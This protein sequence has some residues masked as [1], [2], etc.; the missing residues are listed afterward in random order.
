[1]HE[2][3]R[4]TRVPAL[5]ALGL[6]ALMQLSVFQPDERVEEN[7]IELV[8]DLDVIAAEPLRLVAMKRSE[9]RCDDVVVTPPPLVH[10]E[11]E[12]RPPSLS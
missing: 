9:P 7:D 5:C 6:V 8:C 12:G 11:R 4:Q 2:L 1:M 3:V 10:V